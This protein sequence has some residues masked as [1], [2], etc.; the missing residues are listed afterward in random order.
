M[1]RSFASSIISNPYAEF[2][3][4]SPSLI[5]VIDTSPLIMSLSKTPFSTS[6]ISTFPIS[7]RKVICQVRGSGKLTTTSPTFGIFSKI[8]LSMSKDVLIGMNADEKLPL[9]AAMED[10]DVPT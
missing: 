2:A 1:T 5:L 8:V 9:I 7:E 10:V 3:G 4:I 6:D